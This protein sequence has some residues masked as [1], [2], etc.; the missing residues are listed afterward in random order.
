MGM[1]PEHII[2]NILQVLCI[3]SD[4]WGR[5]LL[6][7]LSEVQMHGSAPTQ[8]YSQIENSPP[9]CVSGWGTDQD[10]QTDEYTK[11]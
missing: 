5:E 6:F 1:L 2:G 9:T 11:S 7:Y 10:R 8:Q 4:T 3:I